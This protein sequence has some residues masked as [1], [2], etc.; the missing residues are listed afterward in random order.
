MVDFARVQNRIYYGYGKA[1]TRLGTSHAVYRS[2][3]GNNPIQSANFLFNQLISVDQNLKYTS[4]R[5]YGDAVWQFLPENGLVLQN[6]DYFVSPSSINYFIVDI[7]PDDRL[8]PPTCVECNGI[9]TLYRPVNT[10][11]PGTNAYQAFDPSTAPQILINC[12][13]SILEHSRTDGGNMKL[14]TSVKLPFYSILVP[15][16]DDI[17]VKTGDVIVDDKG[18][19]LAVINAERTKKV[20]GF[21]ITACELGN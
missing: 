6:Y 14:P 8:T 15:E 1:A 20:S 13:A 19:R 10:R 17:I 11:T 12:P 4:A 9:I 2:A 7:I 21:R 16:F 5:K 3:D 18:R